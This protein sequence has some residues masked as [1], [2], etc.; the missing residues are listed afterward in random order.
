[1]LPQRQPIVFNYSAIQQGMVE[2]LR[3]RHGYKIAIADYSFAAGFGAA[4][5][6]ITIALCKKFCDEF[7]GYALFATLHHAG[8]GQQIR[9]QYHGR[10]I[11]LLNAMH[12]DLSLATK[13]KVMRE[14]YA[15]DH[16]V[17]CVGLGLL[18]DAYDAGYLPITARTELDQLCN[19]MH[20]YYLHDCSAFLRCLDNGEI[21]MATHHPQRSIRHPWVKNLAFKNNQPA[22]RPR[23]LSTALVFHVG[24]AA[25]DP[26]S[27]QSDYDMRAQAVEILETVA[28]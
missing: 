4:T 7:P 13:E 19:D 2:F 15:Q 6:G 11:E 21:P 28:D 25:N 5:D 27:A 16:D 8:H 9:G 14:I 23:K 12:D 26:L 3:D 20:D 1:M 17:S 10:I 24:T 22:L 18:M